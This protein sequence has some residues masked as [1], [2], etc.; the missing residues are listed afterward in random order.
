MNKKS[1]G[2]W[3]FLCWLEFCDA[4]M[5]LLSFN[6]NHVW[7]KVTHFVWVCN[8]SKVKYW[9]CAIVWENLNCACPE[10][11]ISKRNLKCEV[12]ASINVDFVY[13]CREKAFMS[14]KFHP[15]AF[16]FHKVVSIK[17]PWK[18]KVSFSVLPNY[19][20]ARFE[21]HISSYLF[22]ILYEKF[23]KVKQNAKKI[24]KEGEFLYSL[25]EMKVYCIRLYSVLYCFY[26]SFFKG[27]VSVR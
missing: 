11:F 27:N 21:S 16:F 24:A 17:R 9:C 14:E 22:F 2:C 26:K 18:T 12:I 3:I 15:F 23:W 20:C 4:D 8:M 1:S 6:F 5:T 7:N 13:N 25:W 19:F 10:N